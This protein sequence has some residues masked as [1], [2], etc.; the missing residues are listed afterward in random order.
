MD[1][2]EFLAAAGTLVGLVG[3]TRPAG[4]AI[5]DFHQHIHYVGRSDADLVAHQRKLGVA[6]TVLLPAGSRYGLAADAWGNDSVVKL[7]SQYPEEFVYFANELPDLPETRAVLE[8]HLKMGAR[9]IGEQKFKVEC[10]SKAMQLVYSIAQ[11]FDVPVLIHFQHQTYNMGFER[12][13]KMLEKFPGVNFI[14]HAQG[15]WGNIDLHH[16]QEASIR[17]LR[18]PRAA[19]A[20]GCFPTTPTCMETS[21]PIRA[22]LDAAGR[23]PCPRLHRPA[24]GPAVVGQR[25]PRH[26]G[27]GRGMHRIQGTGGRAAPGTQPGRGAQDLPR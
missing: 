19:S 23:G 18:S 1:R 25:L 2:R 8:K 5:I 14:G 13:H 17:K 16:D 21:R 27:R 11:E 20:T 6:K 9:G 12:F 26:P 15:W 3:C 7:A 22:E 24:S 10:D 4:A